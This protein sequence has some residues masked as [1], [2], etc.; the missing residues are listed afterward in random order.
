MGLLLFLLF[1]GSKPRKTCAGCWGGLCVS[2][3]FVEVVGRDGH[4]VMRRKRRIRPYHAE[5]SYNVPREGLRLG[6][7]SLILA[8]LRAR[9]PCGAGC[10]TAFRPSIYS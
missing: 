4:D 7:N 8:V 3:C 10:Y 2:H 5:P 6:S 9:T 1:R